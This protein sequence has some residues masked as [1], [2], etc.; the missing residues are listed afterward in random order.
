MDALYKQFDN[1]KRIE[2]LVD[3]LAEPFKA[4]MQGDHMSNA[5]VDGQQ[6]ALRPDTLDVDDHRILNN[7]Q[8][9]MPEESKHEQLGV[10]PRDSHSLDTP[11]VEPGLGPVL[12]PLI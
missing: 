5:N 11:G 6:Q 9:S 10:L 1:L 4:T 8:A 7:R 2:E 12:S 3:N